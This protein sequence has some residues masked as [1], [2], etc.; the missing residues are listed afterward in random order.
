MQV[1]D[2]MTS[3]I[4]TADIDTPVVDAARL[5]AA[6]DVG[7]LLVT[8]GDELVGL[9]TRKEIIYAQLFSEESYH[10]L[11]LDDIILTP[12]VTIGP[13]ADL[14][15]IISLMNHSGRRYIPVIQGEEI[16]GIVTATD[17]IRVLATMKLIAD[18]R[19]IEESED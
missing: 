5:M 11:V 8:K 17:V 6:D 14:G 16:I 7:S 13:D 12:V 4:V 15:Q 19:S 1:K 3:I 2:F 10:S 9:V 18:G